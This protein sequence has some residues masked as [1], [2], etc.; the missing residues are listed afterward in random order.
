MNISRKPSLPESGWRRFRASS[1][2]SS[3]MDRSPSRKRPHVDHSDSSFSVSNEIKELFNKRF[4]FKNPSDKPWC[5]SDVGE[6]QTGESCHST[7]LQKLKESLNNVKNE[8]GDKE[9]AKW[10]QHTAFTNRAGKVMS[11]VRRFMNAE[12]CT[13]AWCKFHEIL[14]TFH[15]LPEE[16]CKNENLN[17]VHLCEAPG[18]FIASLN[19]YLRS[20]R[21]PWKWQWFANTL[22]PY[23]EGNETGTM[24]MDDRFIVDTLPCW[25]FGPDNTG[26][27]MVYKY[28]EGLI[29]ITQPMKT[30]HLVTADGSFD[31]QD[32]PGEQEALVSPL[33]YCETIT[34]L[35]L[36][37]PKGSF[38]LKLFTLFERSSVC[39]LYLLN[40][41]FKQVHVFKPGTSKSGNSE[42]YAV[43]LNY[44]GK[45]ALGDH[46]NQLE[47]NFGLDVVQKAWFARAAVPDSFLKQLEECCTFFHKRQTETIRENIRLFENMYEADN[48]QMEGKRH[49]AARFYLK[50]FKLCEV[51]RD[52]WVVKSHARCSLTNQQPTHKKKH[53]GSYNERQELAGL[54]WH[55]RI[56]KSW[57]GPEVEQHC[58]P[59]HEVGYALMGRKACGKY[60]DWSIVKGRQLSRLAS[61]PFCDVELLQ[62]MVEA[63]LEY[64]NANSEVAS[65]C[66]YCTLYSR[67]L[68]LRKLSSLVRKQEKKS[69]HCGEA[70]DCLVIGRPEI[71][72][73]LEQP[74]GLRLS[75]HEGVSSPSGQCTVLHDG[76]VGYQ[77]WL[78][79]VVFHVVK[80]CRDGEALILPILSSFT[81]FTA[82]LIFLLHHCFRALDFV[83]PTSSDALGTLAFLLCADFHRPSQEV[84]DF[85]EKL[86]KEVCQLQVS[87]SEQPLQVLEFVPMELLL[88]GDLM[89]FL[90]RLNK[91]IAKQ[92]LH[93]LI[94]AAI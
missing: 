86:I 11:Y 92:R 18:A 15:L 16:L 46:F 1:W 83:C 50:K 84:L 71:F 94:Q 52:D 54:V 48:R 30:I 8:L 68:V 60:C 25:Y 33:H 79:D 22:N 75:Y 28:L 14:G 36:L 74:S 78:L 82:G 34:A 51:A 39:L 9:L 49:D 31:C 26:D 73:C 20:H 70:V 53:S 23:N 55:K 12:L 93:L 66:T 6:V 61:S 29:K 72:S 62:N 81:R 45:D 19:H 42:V 88:T 41:C 17:T 91:A 40:C 7:E 32:N 27:I 35:K 65:H 58:S 64:R 57:L 89:D 21:K 37:S 2:G 69:V 87:E 10:H 44:E 4:T 85:L 38:V 56:R 24:I 59:A 3:R 43:C 80:E 77:K 5:L 76:E 13:Q 67:D 90:S 63:V 47:L